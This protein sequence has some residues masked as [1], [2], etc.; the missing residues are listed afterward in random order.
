[1]KLNHFL[2]LVIIVCS[3]IIYSWG[4]V[5]VTIP[6][7]NYDNGANSDQP[8]PFGTTNEY[9][10][11]VSLY[12]AA[13]IGY[14]GNITKLYWPNR[15]GYESQNQT[16]YLKTT[17][18]TSLNSALTFN[19]YIN[20]A[21][22]VNSGTIGSSTASNSLSFTTTTSFAYNGTDNLLVIV[23]SKRSSTIR[24]PQVQYTNSTNRH[25][26]W[27]S[28]SDPANTTGTL[29]SK[30][31]NI[32]MEITSQVQMV[33]ADENCYCSPTYTNTSDH[34]HSISMTGGSVNLNILNSSHTTQTN[35]FGNFYG[36]SDYLEAAAGA[37]IT[38]SNVFHGT[39]VD[40]GIWVDWNKNGVFDSSEKVFSQNISGAN[41]TFT[42]AFTIPAGQANGNYRMRLRGLGGSGTLSPCGN[43]SWGEARDYKLVVY[44]PPCTGTPTGGTLTLSATYGAPSSSISGVVSGSTSGVSGLA[45]QWQYSD[46]NGS[47]WIDIA[48][49][50]SETL[51][52]TAKN[53]LGSRQYRRK[54][55]C[56]NSASVAY[57][58]VATYYTT[59]WPTFTA[60]FKAEENVTLSSGVSSWGNTSG[61]VG[62]YNVTQATGANQPA[63]I[64]GA[65]DYKEFNYHSR[66][67]F[68]GTNDYLGATAPATDLMSVNGTM[69]SIFDKASKDGTGFSYAGSAYYQLKPNWRYQT[70]STSTGTTS[71][72]TA[73]TIQDIPDPAA[74]LITGIGNN[75]TQVTR[76]NGE[77]VPNTHSASTTYAPSV[78]SSNLRFGAN[79][80]GGEHVNNS[81]AEILLMNTTP[82]AVQIDLVETY[83]SLKYGLTRG[84]NIGTAATFNHVAT[85]GTVIFDKTTNAGFTN[86]IAGIGRDDVSTLN[87]KQSISV[88]KNEP[89][90]VAIYSG[91]SI[92]AN[93]IANGATF[94]SDKSFFIWGNDGAVPYTDY[95]NPVCFTNLPASLGSDPARILRVW[96]AQSTNFNKTVAVGFETSIILNYTPVSNLRL[97]VG[98]SPT[99]WT[100]ATVY[101]GATLNGSRVEFLGVTIGNG[102]YFTLATVN[103]GATPLPITLTD[104][105][106][107]CSGNS[108]DLAWT[109]ASEQNSDYFTVEYSRDG[110]QWNTIST[111]EAAGNTANQNNYTLTHNNTIGEGYYRLSLTNF[112]GK[113]SILK[114]I[115]NKCSTASNQLIAYPNPTSGAFTVNI[116]ATT[117][118]EATKVIVQD[119]TGRVLIEKTVNLSVGSN[120]LYFDAT[121][122]S[123]GTYIIA[124][125]NTGEEKF[126]PIK[127][128]VH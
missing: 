38:V 96:K 90:T 4:Q 73:I 74:R 2:V 71:D 17:S 36:S 75:N 104:F 95:N 77:V 55:T 70:G 28:S 119:I 72:W 116:T 39:N 110:Q 87:Q 68:D 113:Q 63:I 51:S 16:I 88:N 65:T 98:N 49:Q 99:D 12:T 128:V 10:Y 126:N 107:T 6:S 37:T 127:L 19:D 7:S 27:N 102:Q 105:S 91:G 46:D 106:A 112:D 79:G 11:S 109:T 9:V 60:W 124:V 125:K 54:I 24:N 14:S 86:D 81:L 48:G 40:Y 78:G 82:S 114:V 25:I 32:K 34:H 62:V 50:T 103:Y 3:T 5:T 84:N 52:T 111:I 64:G 35:A 93:N 33:C 26:E 57:S 83:L 15:N 43:L 44:T 42:G 97:L 30:R 1:M 115:S 122:C 120:Q 121:T 123:N 23:K 56:T 89:A 59:N 76:I 100:A 47:T 92:P 94:D 108:T 41:P 101:S 18:M 85:D 31:P 20:S 61:S 118:L 80:G 21:T 29:T 13:E 58:S 53:S 69:F 66:I 117:N 8:Y 45:Y 22:I 67:Q